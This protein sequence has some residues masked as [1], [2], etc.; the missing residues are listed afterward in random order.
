MLE[1]AVEAARRAG[2]LIAEQYPTARDVSHKGYRDLVTETDIAAEE[3]ILE[4]IH[5]RFPDHAILS[6]EA[7]GGDIG[8]GYTWVIDPLDGTSN[9]A[10]RLPIFSVSIALLEQGDPI[11]GVVY[12]P[13]R[14][15]LFAGQRG[16]GATLNDEPLQVS[17]IVELE[18]SLV[19]FDWARGVEARKQV[20]SKL[21][22]VA[23]LC[24]TVRSMGSAALGLTYVAAGWLEGYFHLALHP[25]DAAAA[26]LLVAE[27]GGRYT[28]YDGG[29]YDI[30]L[31]RC[32]ATNGLIHEDLL[33]ALLDA[34]QGSD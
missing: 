3:T 32:A 25:W 15:H 31:P 34:L 26:V 7:A 27:A 30:S 21:E 20:L 4:L 5:Q 18:H 17:T 2:Q 1:T 13:M 24:H 11:I 8:A 33:D 28:T 29:A 16:S 10:H 9:Y 6:E 12:D 22:R 23:P 14:E 19:G